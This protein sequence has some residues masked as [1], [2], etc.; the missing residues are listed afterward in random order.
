[1]S[2]K[3]QLVETFFRAYAAASLDEQAALRI[4]MRAM[5]LL[6]KNPARISHNSCRKS[7][8]VGAFRPKHLLCLRQ[9]PQPIRVRHNRGSPEKP[10]ITVGTRIPLRISLLRNL[11]R[12][13]LCPHSRSAI[14]LNFFSVY[15]EFS[16][17][18]VSKYRSDR[19]VA[20]VAATSNDNAANPAA[21]ITRIKCEPPAPK[22]TSIQALKSIGS[23]TGGM[24]MSPS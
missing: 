21:I 17:C 1:M 22:I 2:R 19:D 20:C 10:L 12:F 7:R 14:V 6:K 11:C 9:F 8:V 4:W 24:P 3:N 16:K 23:G 13:G 18:M 15:E 5:I